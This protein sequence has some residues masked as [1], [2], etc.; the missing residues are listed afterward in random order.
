MRE[1]ISFTTNGLYENGNKS[2]AVRVLS[3]L[4]FITLAYT[5][6]P[7]LHGILYPMRYSVEGVIVGIITLPLFLGLWFCPRIKDSGKKLHPIL[8]IGVKISIFIGVLLTLVILYWT[9]VSYLVSVLAVISLPFVAVMF[10][11]MAKGDNKVSGILLLIVFTLIVVVSSTFVL[12]YASSVIE[13]REKAN[14]AMERM[15]TTE[16]LPEINEENARIVPK[17]V[18]E[19]QI[20]GSVS[21][22]QHHIGSGDIARSP[23]GNITWSYPIQPDGIRNTLVENQRGIAMS[24]MSQMENSN[25]QTYDDSKFEVGEGMALHRGSDWNLLKDEYWV[26]YNDDSIDFVHEEEPYMAYTQ[27]GHEWNVEMVGGIIPVPYTTPT[28]DGVSLLHTD[29]TIENYSPD[30]AQNSEVLDGQRLYP[31]DVTKEYIESLNYRN[32]IINQMAIIGSHE[33]EVEVADLPAGAGNSQP[34]LVD[35]EDEQFSYIMALEPYGEDT[36]GLDEVWFT[37]SRTGEF[38]VFETKEDTLLGPERAM[39]V[40]RNEDTQ[41]NW[42]TETT[43]GQFEVIEPVPTVIDG[44]LW[45]HSKVVSTDNLDVSRNVFVNA[46][47][48]NAVESHTTAE[49]IEFI[50]G[51]DNL[52]DL[53]NDT[54]NNDTNTT[55]EEPDENAD[56]DVIYVVTI[57]DEDGN[58]VE[59][60]EVEEG[61]EVNIESPETS[62]NQTD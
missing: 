49:T 1:I 2:L 21:Y 35:M 46:H 50:R 10:Y 23:D 47:T 41:T 30:E 17:E 28:W 38:T 31:F 7:L 55:I 20:K 19:K 32:G 42:N 16:E 36:R 37:D 52:E 59:Q 62:E 57:T 43:D 48:G 27:T 3:L 25:I 44:E 33:N 12:V 24:D 51:M 56:E 11:Y 18:D 39:G 4:L 58:I 13:E 6:R 22:R 54:E 34:F 45:W 40:V 15:E 9:F 61:E 5:W 60:I 14:I 53:P 26:Q 29:G 8:S